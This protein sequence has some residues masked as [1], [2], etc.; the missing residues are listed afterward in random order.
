MLIILIFISFLLY[1]QGSDVH[2][3]QKGETLFSV[4][5]KYNVSVDLLQEYNSIDDPTSLQVGMSIKIPYI[6]VVKKGENLF[7]ISRKYKVDL[8]SLYSLNNLDSNSIIYEGDKILLPKNAK[9]DSVNDNDEVVAVSIPDPASDSDIWPLPGIR[10]VIEGKLD[11]VKISANKGEE[12]ISISSGRVIFCAPIRGYGYVIMV[13]TGDNYIFKYSGADMSYVR[14]GQ[15]IEPGM[16]LGK[17]G[18]NSHDG[19]TKLIFS[20]YLDGNAVDPAKAPRG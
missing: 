20:V 17:V 12:F 6:H 18:E 11:G 8:K 14:F 19:E 5:R 2:I 9:I 10:S 3:L 1:A 15:I 13:R 16:K 7:Q 4:S